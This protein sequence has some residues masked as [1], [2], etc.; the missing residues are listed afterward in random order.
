MP[1]AGTRAW[2]MSC[3][4]AA[5]ERLQSSTWTGTGQLRQRWLLGQQDWCA[6]RNDG[7]GLTRHVS[8]RTVP[9]TPTVYARLTQR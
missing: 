2:L 1:R 3:A 5:C 8:I 6:R 7:A 9:G 4:H